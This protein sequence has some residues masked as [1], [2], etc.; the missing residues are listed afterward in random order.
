VRVRGVTHSVTLGH[1]AF[2]FAS[3]ALGNTDA[4]TF[5]M[6][7][8]FRDGTTREQT[9]SVSAAKTTRLKVKPTLPGVLTSAKDAVA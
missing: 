9:I 4:F 5:T 1:N 8:G 6:I 2:F 7:L 3:N